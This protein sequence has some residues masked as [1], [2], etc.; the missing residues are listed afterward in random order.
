MIHLAKNNNPN[1]KNN[2]LCSNTIGFNVTFD[3]IYSIAVLA[4]VVSDADLEGVFINMSDNLRK[5]GKLIL[6]EQTGPE[7][8]GEI[9]IRRESKKYIELAEKNGFSLS[10]FRLIRFVGYS[11]FMRFVDPVYKK[12]FIRGENNLERDLNANRSF[13]FRLLNELCVFL[14]P[15]KIRNMGTKIGYSF[16]VFT[17]R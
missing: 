3:L 8:R 4:H 15:Y 10:K 16:L 2:I 9:N 7:Q 13:V 17:R 1:I 12:Y 5:D 11:F 14:S 6:F